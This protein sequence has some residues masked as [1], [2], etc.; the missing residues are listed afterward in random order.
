MRL[1]YMSALVF[2]CVWMCIGFWEVCH[3]A[4]REEWSEKGENE[5]IS[6]VKS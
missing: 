5:L 1:R 2:A 6:L 4:K 3:G